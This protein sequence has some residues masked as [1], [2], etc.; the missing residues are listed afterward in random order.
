MDNTREEHRVYQLVVPWN[1]FMGGLDA[2]PADVPLVARD[3][4]WEF[5]NDQRFA[6]MVSGPVSAKRAALVEQEFAAFAPDKKFEKI[7]SFGRELFRT[8]APREL[9]LPDSV[10]VEDLEDGYRVLSVRKMFAP[11]H[12]V[13]WS[14]GAHDYEPVQS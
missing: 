12:Q 6:P 10:T 2:V 14:G 3:L 11:W 4:P 13:Q 5:L 1:F 8:N 7:E 9:D